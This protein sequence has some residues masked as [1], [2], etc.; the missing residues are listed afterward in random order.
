[1]GEGKLPTKSAV[2]LYI[3]F[4]R[5]MMNMIGQS[6]TAV[7]CRLLP[8]KGSL[9]LLLIVDTSDDLGAN[10]LNIDGADFSE[11]QIIHSY[12]DEGFMIKAT[13][14]GYIDD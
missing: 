4:S 1:M 10:C 11:L 12:E 8:G 2:E 7:F 13:A 9:T 14:G 3:F 6:D 5:C